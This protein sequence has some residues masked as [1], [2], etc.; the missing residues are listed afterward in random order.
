METLTGTKFFFLLSGQIT[1]TT[2]PE[3]T[4]L[5]TA[6]KE[7]VHLIVDKCMGPA[8]R[9]PAYFTLNYT[10]IE[11]AQLQKEKFATGAEKK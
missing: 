3:K 6:Y 4:T 9:I 5:D 10:R 1:A 8:T 7:F 2:S 11:L